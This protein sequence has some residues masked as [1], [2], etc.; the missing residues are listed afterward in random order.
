MRYSFLLIL[1]IFF[2]HLS[3]QELRGIVKDSA[4]AQ[5]LAFVSVLV[6]GQITTSAMSDIDGQFKIQ[7]LS[8]PCEL[9]LS[10]VGYKALKIRLEKAPSE[11]LKIQ[12]V[13]LQQLLRVVE[14]QAG[15]NPAHRIIKETWTRR[16]QHDPEKLDQYSCSIYNKMVLTGKPDSTYKPKTFDELAN[17]KSADSLFD[18][19]HLFMIESSNKRYRKGAKVK[20][21]VLGSKISGFKEASFL[22]LALKF[23]PF[24][25][26]EPI[27]EL[28]GQSYVN[29]ISRNSEALY[30]FSLEDT[31]FTGADTTFVISFHPRK[32][33]IFKGLEGVLYISAPDYAI[34]YVIANP[35]EDPSPTKMSI[36]QQYKRMPDGTWFPEQIITALEFTSVNIPGRRTVAESRAYIS[37]V[38]IT[39]KL[40]NSFF[41]E[42]EFE[43]VKD[44]AKRDTLFW[45]NVRVEDLTE[46]EKATYY[47][48]DS[49][50]KAQKIE[51]KVSGLEA[52]TKGYIPIRWFNLD[53]YRLVRRNEHEGFRLGAGGITNEKFSKYIAIGGYGAY[54]FKD[55]VTKYG[56][57]MQLYVHRKSEST[58]RFAWYSDVNESGSVWLRNDRRSMR[59]ELFR[60]YLIARMDAEERSSVSFGFRSFK[61]LHTTL[62]AE[63]VHMKPQY[64]FSYKTLPTDA[65]FSWLETGASLVYSLRQSF[66]R[67]G[68]V[69][70]PLATP[71]PVFRVQYTNGIDLNGG[72]TRNYQ[73]I[74]FRFEHSKIFRR[75]GKSFLQVNAG[76]IEGQLP[77]AKLFNARANFRANADIN[78]SSDNSFETVLM[79]EFVSDKYAS[80]YFAQDLGAFFRIRKFSPSFVLVQNSIIG[81]LSSANALAQSF[82]SVSSPKAGVHEAGLLMRN[83][84]VFNNGGYGVGMYYRYGAT[85]KPDWEKN[86]YFKLNIGFLF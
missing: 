14:I 56:A 66:Y 45:E 37:D 44:A 74:D 69:K 29:P 36:R 64:N 17:V 30:F 1:A 63:Q 83:I 3:A 10:Y 26:Y 11:K 5:P 62:F 77:Y 58:L 23:Q 4:S 18:T 20:E 49:L 68:N 79:N 32:G 54:G 55:R 21:E 38:D 59:N 24:T 73:R 47:Y 85:A 22:T 72:G 82:V 2:N 33:K 27:I 84:L 42:V 71:N 67:N 65:R 86:I 51:R 9:Q 28:A 31:L 13:P 15:E 75:I 40:E 53:I 35:T 48:V 41:D 7:S 52:L 46:Y 61:Y 78:V 57:E 81:T 6:S 80:F 70:L 50:F 16:N 60:S 19:Q 43:V 25:F 12:L 39:T 76:Y 34:N 8:F